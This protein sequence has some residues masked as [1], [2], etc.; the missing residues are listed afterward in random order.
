MSAYYNSKKFK[1]LKLL[2]I[3][4]F[5]VVNY[6]VGFWTS[7][8]PQTWQWRE[9]PTSQNFL[10][11]WIMSHFLKYVTVIGCRQKWDKIHVEVV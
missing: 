6:V 8:K 3:V 1:I 11:T 4:I 9:F 10:P 2:Y 5:V 7:R